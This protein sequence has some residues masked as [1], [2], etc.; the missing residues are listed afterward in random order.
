MAEVTKNPIKKYERGLPCMFGQVVGRIV[1]ESDKGS[2]GYIND[3]RMFSIPFF[4]TPHGSV[5]ETGVL[6]LSEITEEGM[7]KLKEFEA[8]AKAKGNELYDGRINDIEL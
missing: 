5:I 1:G 7:V 6:Y 3:V 8:D 2:W 4:A